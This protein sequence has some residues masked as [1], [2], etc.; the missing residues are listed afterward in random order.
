MI[1]LGFPFRIR[2]DQFCERLGSGGDWGH[3]VKPKGWRGIHAYYFWFP[4]QT[5]VTVFVNSGEGSPTA[6]VQR[7][8]ADALLFKRNP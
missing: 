6:R 5:I 4:D 3:P 7:A 2:K 1:E 8:Y